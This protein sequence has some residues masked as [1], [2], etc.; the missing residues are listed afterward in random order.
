MTHSCGPA[1]TMHHPASTASALLP[2]WPNRPARPRHRLPDVRPARQHRRQRD[3]STIP[4]FRP[5]PLP[6]SRCARCATSNSWAPLR[7]LWCG[8]APRA[9]PRPVSAGST[10]STARL[11]SRRLLVRLASPLLPRRSRGPV[12][13]QASSP[14]Q[15]RPRAVVATRR[16]NAFEVLPG[17]S[18]TAPPHPDSTTLSDGPLTAVPLTTCPRGEGRG[19]GTVAFADCHTMAERARER[20]PSGPPPPGLAC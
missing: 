2:W 6:L 12:G 1:G 15:P 20:F 3:A 9:L 18:R 17:T 16:R 8:G 4:P 14:P 19:G 11:R 5:R 13:L 7:C 10:R